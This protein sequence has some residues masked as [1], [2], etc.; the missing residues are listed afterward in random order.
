MDK[1]RQINI[2]VMSC[3][4]ILLYE[5]CCFSLGNAN[6]TI[7]PNNVDE[8]P[9]PH[10]SKQ[11]PLCSPFTKQLIVDVKCSLPGIASNLI[12]NA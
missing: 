10:G 2:E 9:S 12:P 11:N 7:Q 4:N 8:C 6:N 3:A 5:L 1:E